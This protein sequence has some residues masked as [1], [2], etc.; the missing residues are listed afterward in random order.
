M[1]EKLKYSKWKAADIAKALREGRKPT[2]GAPG[3]AEA[4]EQDRANVEAMTGTQEAAARLA[5]L[6]ATHPDK[7]Q[8]YIDREMAKLA[9]ADHMVE[10]GP[11]DLTSTFSPSDEAVKEYSELTTGREESRISYEPNL[12]QSTLEEGEIPLQQSMRIGSPNFSRPLSIHSP[13]P[14]PFEPS[15]SLSNGLSAAS[16]PSPR[17]LPLPPGSTPRRD[18]LP[19]PPGGQGSVTPLIPPP[20]ILR[21]PSSG[22][23]TNNSFP[24]Q[25]LIPTAPTYPSAP[26]PPSLS[27][28]TPLPSSLDPSAT[29][30]VQKL[31][32]WAVSALD[33]ED[34]ET[35]RIHLREALDI[36]SGKPMAATTKR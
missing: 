25:P 20:H 7:E 3:E 36:C 29:A 12:P 17:P 33:Y 26:S 9:A 34:V 8:D 16:S 22:S 10:T 14:N 13:S 11:I 23:S 28:T 5:G 18:G 1:E 15:A 2:P 6:S 32:K 30:R 21:V 24:S 27:A 35:A 31:A 19:I 4:E